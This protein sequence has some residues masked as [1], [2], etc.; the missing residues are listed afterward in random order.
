MIGNFRPDTRWDLRDHIKLCN[1]AIAEIEAIRLGMAQ[2]AHSD[3]IIRPRVWDAD[4]VIQ[5]AKF[6]LVLRVFEI[7]MLKTTR[8]FDARIVQW[9]GT[10]LLA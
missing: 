4:Q 3:N 8:E 7:N 10:E 9:W 2:Q 1:S 5:S 6:K